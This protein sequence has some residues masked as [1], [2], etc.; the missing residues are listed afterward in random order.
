MSHLVIPQVAH[1]LANL[2]ACEDGNSVKVGQEAGSLE[3]LV[4]LTYS[5]HESVR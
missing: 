5:H 3:A 1:A 2:V 4:E